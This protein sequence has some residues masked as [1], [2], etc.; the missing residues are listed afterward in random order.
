MLNAPLFAADH[1]QV[2]LGKENKAKFWPYG[3]GYPFGGYPW[4][5]PFGSYPWWGKKFTNQ[6]KIQGTK[7]KRKRFWG[8]WGYGW[9]GMVYPGV[10]YPFDYGF[11]GYPYPFYPFVI[12]QSGKLLF[13]IT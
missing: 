3:L 9:P 1:K 13:Q 2:N 8:D 11:G 12:V 4:G 5:Y 7:E 6:E 10:G